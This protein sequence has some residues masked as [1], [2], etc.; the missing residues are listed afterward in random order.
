MPPIRPLGIA[1]LCA[2][3]GAGAVYA[4]TGWSVRAQLQSAAREV[5]NRAIK[6]DRSPMHHPAPARRA[7]GF[8]EEPDAAEQSRDVTS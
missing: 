5:S 2:A 3:L 1:V 6:Q 7:P 8:L 4:A